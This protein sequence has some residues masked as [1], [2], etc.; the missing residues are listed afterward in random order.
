MKQLLLLRHA[1]SSWDDPDLDDF[2][3]PLAE[4]GLKAARLIGRELA[5]R[6]WLP[7]Q[8]LASSALRTRDTWRLVAAELPVHPRVAFA[9]PLY[10]A[11]AADILGQI[12]RVDPSSVCLVVVGHNPGLEDL[13]KQL[14][15]PRSEA[16]AR[17]RLEE[18]FPT[19]ALARFVFEGEWSALFSARLTH[20]LRPKDLS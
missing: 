18:K 13:A 12:H 17:K 10:E 20:C 11:S 15:G 8:A 7:D 16:K 3:R 19:A 4:R 1:K 2:D 14:A 6:D 9:Q 5:A